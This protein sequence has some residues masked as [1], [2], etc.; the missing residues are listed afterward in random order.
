MADYSFVA[1][2]E[3][4][5]PVDSFVPASKCPHK[6]KIARGSKFVCMCCHK[7]GQ[8]HRRMRGL[9]IGSRL[10]PDY[11]HEPET[12]T[13]SY[14]PQKPDAPLTRKQKRAAKF[15]KTEAA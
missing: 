6:R 12:T 8:D 14:A 9:P 2:L 4:L 3:P 11:K 1:E 5:F 7:S 10:N 13:T 15:A